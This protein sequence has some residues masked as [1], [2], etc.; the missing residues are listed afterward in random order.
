MFQPMPALRVIF[1]WHQHQP[2]YKDLV[3][4][5]YRLPWTRLHALKDYFGMV[6]LLEEF[7][8]VHQTFN[9]VPSLM[10][11]IQDYASGNA[12]EPFLRVAAKPAGELTDGERKFALQY[13]FQ[14][15]PTH[16][17]GRYPRYRE[18]MD[19][20]LEHGALPERAVSSF[21]S[22]DLT[23]LQVLSQVAWFDEFFLEEPD[24]VELVKK[25]RGY[26]L[27]D[28]SF[29][30]ARERELLGRV[31][32]VHAEAAKRGSI[33]IS[34]SPFYHPIL[35]LVCDTNA[36]GISTPG[37][38]LPQNRF[39][40]PED[41]R[42][43]IVR[44][45]DLHEKVFGAR[46][47]GMW[48]SEGSVSEEAIQIAQ[49][50]GIQWMATDEGVLGRSSGV[51]FSRDGQGRMSFPLAEKLYN[52]H[53]FDNGTAAMHMV[54]RDH[55]ISDL[56]GFVYSGMPPSDAAAHL[57]H[58]IRESARPV[59]EQ[60]RDAVVSVILDGENA[61]E[62]YPK[63]GRE[64]LRRFYDMLQRDPG[65]EPVTVSEAI[66][67]HKN[68]GQLSSL[69]PGSWINANFNVWIGAP[70]DNRAWDYLYEAREFYSK[71]SAHA[72]EEQRKLAMEELLIAEGS[73]WNW[74]YGP[75]HHTA[76]DRDFDELYR[77]HLSNVY[78]ALG[79]APPDY[80]SQPISGGEVRPAFIP[81]TAYIRPRI[82]GD[83]V[84]YFEWMGAAVY[85]ADQR[86]GAMHGKQFLL[87]GIYGGIDETF[88]YGR[89]DFAGRVPEGNFALVVNIECK[90]NGESA[91]SR[92]LRL[93]ADIAE[94]RLQSWSLTG[95][96]EEPPL[97]SSSKQDDAVRIALAK[98][99]EFRVPLAWL[100]TSVA[101]SAQMAKP[102]VLRLRFSLWQNRL[103]ADALPVEGW[104][105]L[106]LVGEGELG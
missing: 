92:V 28:Q 6:K 59:L 68:F 62:Y 106:A 55:T 95:A 48:P 24:V 32:P 31:L 73:D 33:E 14:A 57:L 30:I 80:L 56:I 8:N 99:F 40:H 25:G 27:E 9:L 52:V 12:Q 81:Q 46:P 63:S 85:T 19:R 60:G 13:L 77:K 22:Q 16:V 21:A 38:P 101:S 103:P 64:F 17:I 91:G 1:L 5:E 43:Q 53:R 41:A 39:R 7:P 29:V 4:G 2:F 67:R 96:L 51:F 18:L 47:V 84:R 23:D 75:E 102:N 61:W 76:N 58:S 78:Q 45:L 88:L 89:L 87:D 3:T 79:A 42:E 74:W 15:N 54:F 10:H 86:A 90:S 71:N 36:G 72:S 35:P 69:V 82:A 66:A 65:V 37:L 97:A 98:N 26:S 34:T 100:G 83:M 49:S 20:Y 94:G 104:L 70:E 11:Q 93:D 105:E 44:G 50:V